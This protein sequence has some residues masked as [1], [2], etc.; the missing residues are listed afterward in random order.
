MMTWGFTLIY[1]IL[2][3]VGNFLCIGHVALS[4]EFL[5]L[6][7]TLSFRYKVIFSPG[8]VLA[9]ITCTGICRPTGS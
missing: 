6:C 5:T 7:S 3:N 8:G 4:F 1:R 2:T 9:Y